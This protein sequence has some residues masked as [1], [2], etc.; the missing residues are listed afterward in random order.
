MSVSEITDRLAARDA[1]RS[2]LLR[3]LAMWAKVKEQ[4]TD[5]ETV[6]RFGFDPE[7]LTT[8]E[9]NEARRKN[10]NWTRFNPYGW[11]VSRNSEG[12]AVIRPRKYNFVRLKTGDVVTLS[13]MVDSPDL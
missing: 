9:R 6:A 12:S 5:P 7:L 2:L 8:S 4:G 10:H 11:P 13:P 1:E 3:T